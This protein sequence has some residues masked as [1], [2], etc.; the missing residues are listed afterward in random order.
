MASALWRKAI[1]ESL[2]SYRLSLRGPILWN[3]LCQLLNPDKRYLQGYIR[4]AKMR[5]TNSRLATDLAMPRFV[6][7]SR[8]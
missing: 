2:L 5:G 6:M 8:I 3:G 1:A 4:V 7:A